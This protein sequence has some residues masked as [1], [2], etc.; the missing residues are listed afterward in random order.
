[1]VHAYPS[2]QSGCLRRR[3]GIYRYIYIG[4]TS[5]SDVL[6]RAK[7]WI[8]MGVGLPDLPPWYIFTL[9]EPPTVPSGSGV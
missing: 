5:L 8:W 4:D 9:V 7:I 2:L 3:G 1:M 6:T